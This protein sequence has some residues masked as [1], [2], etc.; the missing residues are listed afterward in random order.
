[1]YQTIFLTKKKN[2]SNIVDYVNKLNDT[3]NLNININLELL[4]KKLYQ[5]H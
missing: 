1:M 2:S 5:G 3:C 4:S